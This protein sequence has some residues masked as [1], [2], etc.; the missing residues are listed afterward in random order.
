MPDM[1]LWSSRLRQIAS[2]SNADVN[3]SLINKPI[4]SSSKTERPDS[5]STKGHLL[6]AQKRGELT[7]AYRTHRE[8]KEAYTK[9]LESEVVQL[10]AN[11]ARIL[12]ETRALYSEINA[13]KNTLRQNGIPVPNAGLQG[14]DNASHEIASGD[15]LFNL[16][17]QDA[18]SK[19][20]HQ[21]IRIQRNTANDHKRRR[22]ILTSSEGEGV[23]VEADRPSNIFHC[24]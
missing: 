3:R 19:H 12:Q 17:I 20:D 10:R 13:L 9:S 22:A 23:V 11:E 4:K 2:C 6:Q 7:L 1:R 16:S 15:L 8:R 21:R 24:K 14:L 18:R 5:T